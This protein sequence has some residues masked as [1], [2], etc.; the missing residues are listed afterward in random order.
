MIHSNYKIIK[1]S[2]DIYI[3]NLLKQGKLPVKDTGIGFW[4]ATSLSDLFELFKKV[5]LHHKK[6]FIDLGAGD[7]RA[8]LLASLFDVKSHGIEIDEELIDVALRHRREISLPN[9]EKTKFLQKNY[10]EH[11]LSYYDLL[12]ISPDKPFYRDNLDLKLQKELKGKLVVHGYEF[13]P[14]NLKK[15]EEHIINGDKFTVFKNF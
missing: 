15:E 8:V 3:G 7:G 11:D 10:L 9:F 6:S 4:G 2:Y 14:R 1:Q 12:Y 5:S 13:L